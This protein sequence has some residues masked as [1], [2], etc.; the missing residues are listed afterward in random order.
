MRLGL[1]AAL[2]LGFTC[3]PAPIRVVEPAPDELVPA[4]DL[5]FEAR[6]PARFDPLTIEVAIDGVGVL[7]AL[8]LVPPFVDA[9]GVVM[10]G[11][12]PVLASELTLDTSLVPPFVVTGRL[13]GLPQGQHGFEVEAI[14]PPAVDPTVVART[15]H[16]AGPFSNPV[17][18]LPAAIQNGVPVAIPS[19]GSLA[20]ASLADPLAGPPVSAAGSGEARSGIVPA[21][22]ALIQ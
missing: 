22:E 10:V 6:V 12:T 3:G 16:H 20:N 9:G 5:R 7:A 4:N 2:L 17:A 18:A 11:A 15:F 13:V 14:D 1:A 19:G 8:G 21:A